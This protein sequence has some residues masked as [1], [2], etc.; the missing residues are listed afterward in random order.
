[1]PD[2]KI[3]IALLITPDAA[4][5]IDHDGMPSDRDLDDDND[6]AP[7]KSDAFPL[8]S[9]EWADRDHDLIGDH[10]DA[11]IDADGKGDDKNHNGTPDY[12]EFDF[13]GDG[14]PRTKAVPW[15]AFPL[16]PKEWRDTDGDGI[17]DNADTDDDDD[18]W[19]D[20]QEKAAGTDPLRRLSFPV[21]DDGRGP[22][23][24]KPH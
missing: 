16:D 2:F 22:R 24:A 18:G 14:V 11:D 20:A 3:D 12:E 15:D 1:V 19:S 8:E 5:D 21:P 6:G 7:D 23:Q 10:L 9:A 13:D 4:P 17:G